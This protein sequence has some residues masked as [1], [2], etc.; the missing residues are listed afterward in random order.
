[1]AMAHEPDCP[2]GDQRLDELFQRYGMSLS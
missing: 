1:V 2:A